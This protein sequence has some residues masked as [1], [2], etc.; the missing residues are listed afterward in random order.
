MTPLDLVPAL[1]GALEHGATLDVRHRLPRLTLG[2]GTP[3]TVRAHL[4]Q[5]TA[6]ARASTGPARDALPRVQLPGALA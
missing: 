6:G 3:A 4:G 1:V 2:P 5:S